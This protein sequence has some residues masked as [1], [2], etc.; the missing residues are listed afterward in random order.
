MEALLPLLPHTLLACVLLNWLVWANRPLEARWGSLGL[1][2]LALLV[3]ILDHQVP[4]WGTLV[5]L[6]SLLLTLGSSAIYSPS[7]GFLALL[8]SLQGSLAFALAVHVFGWQS[9]MLDPALSLGGEPFA[10]KAHFDKSFA[11]A[12]IALFLLMQPPSDQCPGSLM[13]PRM[14]LLTVSGTLILTGLTLCMGASLNPKL[15]WA[16]IGFLLTNLL[17][18]VIPEELFFRGLIQAYLPKG[19]L[20]KNTL[21]VSLTALFFTLA[22]YS[23]SISV[24]YLGLVFIA[25]LL[26]AAVY[27]LSRSIPLSIAAHLTVNA[28][29]VLLFDYPIRLA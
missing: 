3:A 8:I 27:Q 24:S 1:T 2:S 12:L 6:T 19:N 28:A 26:Y 20:Q 23:S 4:W 14:I 13:R 29:S 10:W 22:H 5:M 15:G 25:G 21:T 18:T 9:V 17:F 16:A 11:A 7:K